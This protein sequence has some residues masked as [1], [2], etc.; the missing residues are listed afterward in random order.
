M[1]NKVILIGRLTADPELRYTTSGTAYLKLNVAVNRRYK[2]D[3]G[4][5][6]ADFIPVTA[7]KKTAE[8]ISK[9][10]FKGQMIIIEGSLQ[11]NNYT[12]QNGVKHYSMNVNAENVN[13]CGSKADNSS[14]PASDSQSASQNT[15]QKPIQAED[16]Q[17][18]D[19]DNFA[20]IIAGDDPPF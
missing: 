20:D 17:L 11:N 7:W 9:Y 6:Q 8:F 13:F 1:L 12:D 19:L 5:Q 18:G 15:S 10:F 14:T 2:K 16:I 4:E 3:D